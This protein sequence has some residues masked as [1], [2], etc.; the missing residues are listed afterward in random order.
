MDARREGPTPGIGMVAAGPAAPVLRRDVAQ[1]VMIADMAID[2]ECDERRIVN[3]EIVEVSPDGKSGAE[4][5]SSEGCGKVVYYRIA[6]YAGSSGGHNLQRPVRE[7]GPM[8][9]RGARSSA[10]G[11][12]DGAARTPCGHTHRAMDDDQP[13]IRTSATVVLSRALASSAAFISAS[14]E[15]VR[16]APMSERICSSGSVSYRP[17]L[18]NR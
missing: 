7:A 14:A 10:S 1:T 8:T 15:A 6:F 16:S 2:R 13:T 17:S 12:R 3:N 9:A 5:W 11:A 4:H 18:Q